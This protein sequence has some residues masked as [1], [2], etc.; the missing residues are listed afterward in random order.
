M[1]VIARIKSNINK[2]QKSGTEQNL[3]F[4]SRLENFVLTFTSSKL[5]SQ[6]KDGHANETTVSFE[7]HDL[8]MKK[9]TLKDHLESLTFSILS[10]NN[11]NNYELL[12]F[13]DFNTKLIGL[14]GEEVPDFKGSEDKDLKDLEC[15]I[16]EDN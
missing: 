3:L 10:G 13:D 2:L 9:K 14:D 4:A 5:E 8:G 1:D 15:E 16:N 6:R 11:K 12:M 7:N